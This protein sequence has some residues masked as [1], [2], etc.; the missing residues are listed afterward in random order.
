MPDLNAGLWL[1]SADYFFG[2]AAQQLIPQKRSFTGYSGGYETAMHLFTTFGWRF[3]MSEDLNVLP[4]VMIKYVPA[5]GISPQFEWT[6]K[7]QFRDVLWIGGAYRMEEG[8]A[9]M[10]GANLANQFTIGYS[11]DYTASK[12]GRVNRGSHE[13]IIGFLI[14][15][16]YGDTCPRNLW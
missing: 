13:L 3:L 16:R 2:V 14:G 12:L 10:L 8:F 1:Y 7:F 5:T 4:A 9:G 11:F 15:N 6:A